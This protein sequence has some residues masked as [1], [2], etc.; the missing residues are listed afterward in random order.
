[1]V[2]AKYKKIHMCSAD[3]IAPGRRGALHAAAWYLY[4]VAQHLGIK[5]KLIGKD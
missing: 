3:V 2:P 1:M 5:F 4:V